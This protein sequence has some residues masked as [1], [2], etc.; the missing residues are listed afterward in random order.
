M[1][2]RTRLLSSAVCFSLA[3]LGADAQAFPHS[4][5]VSLSAGL[6]HACALLADHHVDCWGD[7]TLGTLPPTLVPNLSNAVEITSGVNFNCARLASQSVWCWGYGIYGELG[8]T[9]THS[10]DPVEVAAYNDF[11]QISAGYYHVCGVRQDHTAVCW[12]S[13]YSDALGNWNVSGTSWQPVQ[14]RI[15]D[16]PNGNPVLAGIAS[17]SAGNGSTC[18][19]LTDNSVACWGFNQ[20]GEVGN[21]GATSELVESPV[22]VVVSGPLLVIAPDGL[23]AGATHYCALMGDSS[24]ACWG[25]NSFGELGNPDNNGGYGGSGFTWDFSSTPGAVVFP[26]R[27]LLGV[28]SVRAG[29]QLS[30]AVMADT[31]VACWGKN[32]AGQLGNDAYTSSYSNWPVAVESSGNKLS[33]VKQ[34]AVA[35]RYA[36]ALTEIDS[37]SSPQ[38]KV[39]CWGANSFGQLGTGASD[40]GAHY[41]PATVNIDSPIFTDDFESD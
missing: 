19:T 35:G 13:N 8:E 27:E 6:T 15:H 24:I 16:D 1:D 4:G 33:H 32:D 25:Q 29:D 34:L 18:A 11:I 7:I 41:V 40:S 21:T 17:I 9:I 20:Q 22:P 23:V 5:I 3:A 2:Y 12:G 26:D 30:C 38:Q 36:C 28:S 10:D 39:Y 14:V 31:T 37:S